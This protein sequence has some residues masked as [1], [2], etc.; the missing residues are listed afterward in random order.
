MAFKSSLPRYRQWYAKL[1]RLYPEQYHQRFGE[2]MEQTFNDL[3]REH[4][5]QDRSLLSYT[6]WVFLETF[7]K[8]L[9]H[10][11]KALVMQNKNF[12]IIIAATG[13]LLL[14]PLI[15]MQFSDDVVWTVSDFIFAAVLLLGSGFTFELISRQGGNATYRA[16]VGLGVGASL[17]LVWV[18]GAVGLIG[19][20]NNDANILY[21]VVLAV[22]LIG[23]VIARFK[24]Q[25]MAR[26]MFA[27]AITQALIPVVASLIWQPLVDGEEA[28]LGIGVMNIVGITAFF[29]TLFV[30]SGILFLQSVQRRNA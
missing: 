12:F 10:K 7:L 9:Q 17:L 20:E 14:V 13:L 15:A 23:A 27:M 18:N 21:A 8:I 6:V 30:G 3:L 1:L 22:G 19:T 2:G 25:A 28:A 24:P 4:A 26:T 5:D 16:A 29:V 11:S